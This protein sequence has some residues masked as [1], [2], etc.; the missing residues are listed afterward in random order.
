LFRDDVTVV[1]SIV[2][3]QLLEPLCLRPENIDAAKRQLTHIERLQGP[4]WACGL[5]C[6]GPPPPEIKGPNRMERYY[7]DGKMRASEKKRHW[8]SKSAAKNREGEEKK[9]GRRAAAK[10]EEMGN[11]EEAEKRA[12]EAEMDE[13]FDALNKNLDVLIDVAQKQGEAIN[14]TK[15][16][17]KELAGKISAQNERIVAADRRARRAHAREGPVCVLM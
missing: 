5:C 13:E 7:N 9:R 2:F 1:V 16:I 4:F 10:E 15:K 11:G 17:N 14:E 6:G 8:N 3:N 12:Y